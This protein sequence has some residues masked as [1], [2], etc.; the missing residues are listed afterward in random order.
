MTTTSSLVVTGD[1]DVDGHTNLD[2]VSVAGV[3]TFASNLNIGGDLQVTGNSLFVG[4]VTFSA[5]TDGTIQL[6]S[7]NTDN[8]V[9]TADV[10]SNIV[11]NT[12][13]AYDLG[14]SSQKWRSLFVGSDASIGGTVTATS[15]D[16]NLNALGNTY[17]VSENGDNSNSGNNINEPFLTITRV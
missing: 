11:P 9:F 8:V 1:V 13:N 5:G 10:N 16:G 7:A 12:N 4:V 6:G 3:S 14:S 2:N 17:Y 15:F